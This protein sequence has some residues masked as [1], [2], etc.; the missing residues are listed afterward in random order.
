MS[1]VQIFWPADGEC[2][3][4]LTRGPCARDTW[5]VARG[6]HVTCQPRACP[7]DP[8]LPGLC[9]VELRN[10]TACGDTRHGSCVVAL[11][12]EQDGHCGEGEQL[13]VW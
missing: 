7:C 9:E 13:L 4:L 12:A 11:A 10:V 2:Y 1:R 5:L 3:S 8:A 6:G